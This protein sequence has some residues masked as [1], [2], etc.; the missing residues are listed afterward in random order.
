MSPEKKR[1]T[2]WDLDKY[3]IDDLSQI[4]LFTNPIYNKYVEEIHLEGNEIEDPEDIKLLQNFPKLKALWLNDNPVVKRTPNF[5]TIGN[6]FTTLE[7]LN[8]QFTNRAGEW[9]IL[10]LA[11]DTGEISLGKITY[12]NARGNNLLSLTNLQFLKQMKNLKKLDISDNINMFKSKEI[13]FAE[14]E[15]GALGESV[16]IM[17]NINTRDALLNEL[18]SLEHLICDQILEDYILDDTVGRAKQGFLPR[19]E[20]INRVPITEKNPS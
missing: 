16:E 8:G 11:R 14:A 2:R 7:L 19:L 1:S 20:S 10:Y 9:A 4:E 12:L 6:Y 5:N 17:E 13:L 15:E 3:K 18:K